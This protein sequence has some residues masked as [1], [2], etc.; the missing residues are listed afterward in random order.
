MTV[1]ERYNIKHFQFHDGAKDI[2]RCFS[3]QRMSFWLA[4]TAA[5]FVA[6]ILVM[7]T[8]TDNTEGSNTRNGKGYTKVENY[9][10]QEEE[11]AG[12]PIGIIK[13]YTF[14]VDDLIDNDMS[15]GFYTVHQYV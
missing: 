12:A 13:K 1:D 7:L 3:M 5:V 15:L 2:R 14:V 11:D 8:V 6:V 10:C 9:T 4:V